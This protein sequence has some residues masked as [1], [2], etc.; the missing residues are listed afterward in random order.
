[1]TQDRSLANVFLDSPDGVR[2]HYQIVEGTDPES[3]ETL[4]MTVNNLI[5]ER[6]EEGYRAATMQD[7][8]RPQQTATVSTQT[9]SVPPTEVANGAAVAM[10]RPRFCG[11]TGDGTPADG[12]GCGAPSVGRVENRPKDTS[13]NFRCS[14]CDAAA[15][16]PNAKPPIFRWRASTR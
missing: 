12:V 16:G 4:A 10:Q 6:I 7:R 2:V 14:E 13:P 3:L 15:W 1:M 11:D 8:G 5:V 9:R